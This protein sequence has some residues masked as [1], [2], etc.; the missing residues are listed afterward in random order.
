M[1][2]G[3]CMTSSELSFHLYTRLESIT[4]PYNTMQLSFVFLQ[5][6][7]KCTYTS[8]WRRTSQISGGSRNSVRK[9]PG[10]GIEI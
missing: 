9:A 2:V 5:E 6:A 10:R 8:K 4:I 7:Q 1:D 3:L